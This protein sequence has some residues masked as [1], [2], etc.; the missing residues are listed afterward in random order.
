M[1]EQQHARKIDTP[2][3]GWRWSAIALLA[4]VVS[5]LVSGCGGNN[6]PDAAPVPISEAS[7]VIGPAG[8]TL[9]GPDGTQVVVPPQALR[10]DTMIRIARSGAGAPADQPQGYL[11]QGSVYE[12]TPHDIV[13]ERP[14][15]MRVPVPAAAAASGA[16]AYASSPTKPWHPVESTVSGGF[17]SWQ[18][19]S[20]SWLQPWACAPRL[21]DP[22]PCAWA[23]L[24]TLAE[25]ATP[26]A[27]TLTGIDPLYSR[28]FALTQ[29]ATVRLAAR[30]QAARDCGDARLTV[31]RV[32]RRNNLVG[33]PQMLIDNLSV[34]LTDKPGS[35]SISEGSH[36]FDVAFTDA[37]NGT[38]SFGSRISC[39]RAFQAP[40]TPVHRQADVDAVVIV[41]SAAPA[42]VAPP[43]ITQ[44]PASVAV[45][46]G[47]SAAFTLAA[48][49]PDSLSLDWQRSNNAGASWSS[50]NSS[51]T[52]YS[53]IAA[54][55]DTGAQFRARVCNVKGNLPPNCIFTSSAV[56]TVNV[57]PPPPPTPGNSKISAGYEHT[58][59]IRADGSLAC[60]G[61]NS[62]AQIG[63]GDRL[64]RL[65]P[66]TVALPEATVSVA[67]GYD[68]T[69]A[70]G[71]SGTLRCWGDPFAA[72]Q[73]VIV[74]G[75]NGVDVGGGGIKAVT[76]GRGHACLLT[77][78]GNVWC[79][80]SN[81]AGQLGNGT[82][83]YSDVPVLVLGAV[84]LPLADVA[85]ISAH[86]F[87]TCA[88]RNDGSVAC[89]GND[90]LP[91]TSAVPIGISNAT[92]VSGEC[93]LLSNGTVTCWTGIA[94][95]APAAV[96]GLSDVVRIGF[97]GP[98][99]A[100]LGTGTIQCWGA[101][102][103]GNGQGFEVRAAPT[104]VAG[105]DAVGAMAAGGGHTCA[106]RTDAS[107]RCWG[108]GA[109]GQLGV[110]DSGGRTVPTHVPD[111]VGW[112]SP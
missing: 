82:L 83:V 96:A 105:L 34:G 79:R 41:V 67:A 25:T 42:P 28:T 104:A 27:L 69:C 19:T 47:G 90:A 29:A 87:K 43:V 55:G 78:A 39:Q 40:A 11:P 107:L 45:N 76:V 103:F 13:F 52:G 30:Y 80:G 37:D 77:V 92:D 9:D 33:A 71:A 61:Y 56:L 16:E 58:C 64:S 15:A 98:N 17:A 101:G 85:R 2:P 35:A 1:N 24:I 57:P 46:A 20:F 81:S 100:L 18:S 88:V 50:L 49:A 74:G 102:V 26:G 95:A 44:Q 6:E 38:T 89:W 68:A 65:S 22:Y 91:V 110:G 70:L 106:L 5:Y 75:V 48:T 63:V 108:S 31:T 4:L 111:A 97:G 54:A 14:V 53:L 7:A 51:G 23:R 99:C 10:A 72:T 73:P 8:G 12:F 62:S 94:N 60:W 32:D 36:V 3:V 66:T 86:D 21:A 109:R 93:A 112:A 59:A 84:G